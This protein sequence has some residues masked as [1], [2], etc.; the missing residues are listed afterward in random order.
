M[1]IRLEPGEFVVN[2]HKHKIEDYE[3]YDFD[4]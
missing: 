1:I 3:M 2:K 4:T